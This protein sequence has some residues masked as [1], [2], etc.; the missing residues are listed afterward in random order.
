MTTTT[1]APGEKQD[2]REFPNR[3]VERDGGSQRLGALTTIVPEEINSIGSDGWEEFEMAVDSGASE[4][5]VGPDM[6][7]SADIKEGAA[8]KRGVVYEVANGVRIEKLGEKTFIG[9]K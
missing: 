8:C 7:C 3:V 1:Y 2:A 5:V 6:I 4:T 9:T